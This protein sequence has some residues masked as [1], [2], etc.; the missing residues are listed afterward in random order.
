MSERGRR[1]GVEIDT[2]TVEE[3]GRL[4]DP[5]GCNHAGSWHDRHVSVGIRRPCPQ[6][7]FVRRGMRPAHILDSVPGLVNTRDSNRR[8]RFRQSAATRLPGCQPRT[9][10]GLAAVH[11]R[12]RSLDGDRAMEAVRR[13]RAALRSG[14][15]APSF[16]RRVS[17]VPWSCRT[18]ARAGWLDRLVVQ[19]GHRHRGA[20]ASRRRA[21]IGRAARDPRQ[22]PGFDL[23]P[24]R[25]GPAR[26]VQPRRSRVSRT[27]RRRS[28]ELEHQPTSSIQTICRISSWL[29][30]AGCKRASRSTPSRACGV[31]DGEYRWFHVRAVRVDDYDG[32]VAL[33]WRQD[34]HPRQKDGRRCVEA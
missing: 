29:A 8:D 32:T 28:E 11:P 13:N 33:V 18:G 6:S 25:L 10:S 20:E 9:A 12:I 2:R 27:L 19:P 31:T 30:G 15:P 34:R 17:L 3:L 22:H 23:D 1:A 4:K 16:R 14:L 24:Q 26:T 21:A 7:G 5:L